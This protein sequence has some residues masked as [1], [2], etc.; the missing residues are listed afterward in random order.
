MQLLDMNEARQQAAGEALPAWARRQGGALWLIDTAE[1][2][3]WLQTP[4]ASG[5][6]VAG[7]GGQLAALRDAFKLAQQAG[8]GAAD[9]A[10]LA[11]LAVRGRLPLL[12]LDEALPWVCE[13]TRF[14]PFAVADGIYGIV[15]DLARLEMALSCGLRLVQLRA[16]RPLHPDEAA[17]AQ[18]LAV[19]YGAQLLINDDWRAVLASAQEGHGPGLH[20]GQEDLV[21]L[22]SAALAALRAQGGRLLLGLSSHCPWELARAAG[23]GASYIACGPV[24]PTTTKSMPWQ[25]QGLDNLAWWVAHAPAPVVAIGG[26]L[27]PQD[28]RWAA[29]AGPA[30][31]CVV[32]GLG[33]SSEAMPRAIAALQGALVKAPCSQAPVPDWPHPALPS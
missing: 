9:A 4:E 21:A 20:L 7:A 10:V 18:A 11:S 31:V 3:D 2:M 13:G 24:K 27:T 16:K 1:G 6:L 14:A 17:Q 5:Y 22:P 19:H 23:C 32:R 33:E 28:V 12:G 29:S 30:A 26:L 15:P 8:H 25:A